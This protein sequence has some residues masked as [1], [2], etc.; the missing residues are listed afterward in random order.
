MDD[1]TTTLTDNELVESSNTNEALTNTITGNELAGDD[2]ISETDDGVV[3]S[4][5]NSWNFVPSQYIKKEI[6]DDGEYYP[7]EDV[8]SYGQEVYDDDTLDDEDNSYEYYTDKAV[9]NFGFNIL[10]TNEYTE[11]KNNAVISDEIDLGTFSY[12]SIESEEE[13]D[14]DSVIEYSIISGTTEIP[15][16]PDNHSEVIKEKLFYGLNTRFIEDNS[17]DAYEIYE[18]GQ[19]TTKQSPSFKDFEQHEYIVKYKAGGDPYKIIPSQSKIKIKVVIRNSGKVNKVIL[20]KYG[21]NLQ[22]N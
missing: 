20:K 8:P 1:T 16:I 9:Y 12:I 21:G 6:Y 17:S 11:A 18:D 13:T 15:I 2:I 5:K 22:W 14:D 7:D 3:Y 19:K 4:N 10:N